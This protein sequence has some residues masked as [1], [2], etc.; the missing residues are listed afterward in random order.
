MILLYKIFVE[1]FV[2]SFAKLSRIA[3]S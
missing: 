1:T 3:F 2:A